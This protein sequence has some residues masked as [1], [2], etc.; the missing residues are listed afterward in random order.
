MPN[1]APLT[2]LTKADIKSTGRKLTFPTVLQLLPVGTELPP[3]SQREQTQ[4]ERQTSHTCKYFY[5]VHHKYLKVQLVP[6]VDIKSQTLVMLGSYHRV[7]QNKCFPQ[8][9]NYVNQNLLIRCI[10]LV[11]LLYVCTEMLKQIID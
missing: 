6:W 2:Y 8:L 5:P 1:Q 11:V 10:V 4:E 7:T 3:S 9:I